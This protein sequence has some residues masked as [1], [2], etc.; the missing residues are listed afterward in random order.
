[1][2]MYQL[3]LA[4]SHDSCLIRT[5]CS[6]RAA[7]A[8]MHML[9]VCLKVQQNC[10]PITHEGDAS[11]CF[12]GASTQPEDSSAALM[13]HVCAVQQ[14]CAAGLAHTGPDHGSEPRSRTHH[15]AHAGCGKLAC[16]E[17]AACW[18]RPQRRSEVQ[19]AAA[20]GSGWRRSGRH[21]SRA[22]R[23]IQC[24]SPCM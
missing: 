10:R 2:C 11:S 8:C 1:M 21:A 6:C 14:I 18:S 17:P 22:P 4:T 13:L 9:H 7:L 23:G 15:A 12:T 24:G 19:V 20:R 3:D 16:C 5:M